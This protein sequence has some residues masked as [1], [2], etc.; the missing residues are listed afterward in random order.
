[1]SSFTCSVLRKNFLNLEDII[2]NYSLMQQKYV[3]DP[4]SFQ[5]HRKTL[6]VSDRWEMPFITRQMTE[7]KWVTWLR[8]MLTEYRKNNY[9]ISERIP[10]YPEESSENVTHITLWWH[11]ITNTWHSLI[12]SMKNKKYVNLELENTEGIIKVKPLSQ[13]LHSLDHTLDRKQTELNCNEDRFI[14]T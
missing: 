9:I 5:H 1:M 7:T 2:V 4:I 6:S 10:H 8:C 14:S 11:N 12:T 13:Y 3:D